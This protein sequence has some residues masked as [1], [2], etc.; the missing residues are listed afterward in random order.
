MVVETTRGSV[1]F[2]ALVAGVRAGF[3]V[4]EHEGVLIRVVLWRISGWIDVVHRVSY[5]GLC[6]RLYRCVFLLFILTTLAL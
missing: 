3:V 5:G 4:G 6:R 2:A 1:G